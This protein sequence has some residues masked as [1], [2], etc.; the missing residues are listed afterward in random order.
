[1]Y[2]EH[3]SNSAHILSFSTKSRW[4]DKIHLRPFCPQNMVYV[5]F[6]VQDKF[7]INKHLLVLG[8]PAANI[9]NYPH[10][11]YVKINDTNTI[12]TYL[13]CLQSTF[14]TNNDVRSL[15]TTHKIGWNHVRNI[16]FYCTDYILY[17][18]PFFGI[19]PK[20]KNSC[21]RM[22]TIRYLYLSIYTQLYMQRFI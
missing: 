22:N 17:Y 4:A 8:I 3:G 11:I 16:V 1:M 14:H 6:C 7:W 19:L 12:L 9:L 10:N 21:S 13:I 18:R 20:F 15:N 5:N 2:R